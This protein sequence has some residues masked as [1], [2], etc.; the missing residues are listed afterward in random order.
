MKGFKNLNVHEMTHEKLAFLARSQGKSMSSL[1][2]DVID[3]L[4]QVGLN[5]TSNANLEVV[6]SLLSNRVT[7][8]FSGKSSFQIG[9]ISQEELENMR[10][11]LFKEAKASIE[12]KKEKTK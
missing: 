4:F 6:V 2:D 11:K 3:A 1:L 9:E 12:Q 5:F 7:F 8:D 10:E